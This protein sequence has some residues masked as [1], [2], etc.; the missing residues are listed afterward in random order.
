MSSRRKA[1]RP[2]EPNPVG[3]LLASL[4]GAQ[5]QGGCDYCDAYQTIRA[6]ALGSHAV[7]MI[8]VHHDD[9]CPVLTAHQLGV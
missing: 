7:H 2:S 9:W 6:H 3:E 8:T 4:D 1:S 5:I